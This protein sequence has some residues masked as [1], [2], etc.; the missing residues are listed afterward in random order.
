MQRLAA[1]SDDHQ[2][3]TAIENVVFDGR[4][5]R[6]DG[7]F[8]WSA[9][10]AMDVRAP[11]AQLGLQHLHS[12]DKTEVLLVGDRY[13]YRVDPQ[14]SGPLKGRHWMRT[15]LPKSADG[16]DTA[17]RGLQVN[18]EDGLRMLPDATG[19]TDLGEENLDDTVARHY[20]GTVTRAALSADSRLVQAVGTSPSALLAGADSAELD[21]WSGSDGK[22]VRWVTTLGTGR[23][24]AVDLFDFGGPRTITPPAARDTTDAAL[25]PGSPTMP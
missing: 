21:V 8:T 13:Y 22:P 24:V 9:Q 18:P 20:R 23:S 14:P 4:K 25:I 12:A 1:W 6:Y 2:S 15:P 10:P 11:T 19:W 16:S 7:L 3:V 17:T 5:T